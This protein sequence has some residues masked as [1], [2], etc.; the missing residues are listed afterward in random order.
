MRSTSPRAG[1][2]ARQAELRLGPPEERLRLLRAEVPGVDGHA[3]EARGGAH[4]PGGREIGLEAAREVGERAPGK[5]AHVGAGRLVAQHEGI[6]LGAVQEPEAHARVGRMEERALA[7]DE[8]P[9]VLGGGGA[10]LLDRP[11]HEVRDDGVHR[12]PR[13]FDEDAGLPGCPEVGLDPPR[14]ER[15]VQAERRVHLAHRAV[16]AHGEEPRPLRGSPLPIGN[17][18]SGCRTSCRVRPPRRAASATAGMSPSLAW[19]PLATSMPASSAATMVS[20]QSC[21]NTPP[22]VDHADEQG[23]GASRPTFR[24]REL[25][26]I[27]GGHASRQ[28]ELPDARFRAPLP[29]PDRGLG[30]QRVVGVPQKEEVGV[31]DAHGLHN[32]AFRLRGCPFGRQGTV[33]WRRLVQGARGRC[34]TYWRWLARTA[35]RGRASRPTSRPSR[36]SRCTAARP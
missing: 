8:V 31:I 2:D 18:P 22:P 26:E 17:D 5:P 4:H 35:A 10:E 6:G 23:A 19:S 20:I 16:R 34:R 3:D 15:S 30:G 11:R 13:A 1:V 32:I 21:A 14:F 27:D 28:A 36:P 12:D 9:V 25:G 7:L 24:H 29:D 33:R